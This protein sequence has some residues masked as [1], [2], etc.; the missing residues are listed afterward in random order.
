MVKITIERDNEVTVKQG[1]L[2][3]GFILTDIGTG[4][5]TSI[6]LTGIL[7]AGCLPHVLATFVFKTL[8]EQYEDALDKVA[9]LIQ[10]E[11]YLEE[12]TRE[13]MLDNKDQ[14]LSRL[15]DLIEGM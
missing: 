3:G 15:D 9:A 6:H 5:D 4:F 2:T 14:V 13:F 8:G 7:K 10:T 12:M 1:D 11:E